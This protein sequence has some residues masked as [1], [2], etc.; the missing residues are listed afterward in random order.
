MGA[1]IAAVLLAAAQGKS[2]VDD[3][4]PGS[5]VVVFALG[6][7]SLPTK[8]G[9]FA[10]PYYFAEAYKFQVAKDQAGV[11]EMIRARKFAWIEP[12]TRAVIIK[13]HEGDKPGRGD[14]PDTY[15]IRLKS[16][17]RPGALAHVEP[18]EV[19]P[20]DVAPSTLDN[21]D[22]DDPAAVAK[23]LLAADRRVYRELELAVAA[24]MS[25]TLKYA[26]QPERRREAYDE[27]MGRSMVTLS[28]RHRRSP[29]R[30]AEL[31]ILGRQLRWGGQPAEALPPESNSLAHA[32]AVA[33]KNLESRDKPA[34][35]A[36]YRRVCIDYPGSA[37]AL[38]ARGRLIEMDE[39]PPGAGDKK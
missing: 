31:V 16:G 3:Y 27:V 35:I 13:R 39:S 6:S 36:G 28:N 11:D 7:D 5:E 37:E 12:G 9:G 14:V 17:A 4:R 38:Y 22:A 18:S 1:I 20:M 32:K 24:A 29:E 2:H 30:L 8:V 10:S 25:R 21:F 26:R 19:R 15:E 34:A 33:A 23:A